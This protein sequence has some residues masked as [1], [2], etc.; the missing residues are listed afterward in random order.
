[1]HFLQKS[2]IPYRASHPLRRLP[3]AVGAILLI[4][5]LAACNGSSNTPTPTPTVGQLQYT[6]INLKLPTTAYSAQTVGPLPGTTI[7]KLGVSFKVNPKALPSSGNGTQVP[8]GQNN[9]L[10]KYANAYGITDATYQKIEKYLGVEGVTLNLGKLHSYMTVKAQASTVERLF[11]TQ[12]VEHR[13]DKRTYYIPTTAPR[14]PT[15]VMTYVLAITGLESYSTVA[16]GIVHQPA[17][18]QNTQGAL[19]TP[20]MPA[21]NKKQAT[22]NCN[23]GGGVYP[24]SIANSYGFNSFYKKGYSGQHM[25]VNLIELGGLMSSDMQN[26]FSCVNFP[27][28]QLKFVDVDDPPTQPSDEATLDVE[29]IA[30]LDNGATIMDYESDDTTAQTL[31]SLFVILNDELQAIVND[32]ASTNVNGSVVS[33]SY[34]WAED[35]LDPNVVAAIDQSLQTLVSVEHMTVFV[36]SGDCGAFIGGDPQHLDVSFPASDPWSTAVGGTELA[37]TGQGSRANE[38]VWG[39]HPAEATCKSNNWGSGGGVSTIFTIPS[40]QEGRGV[41]NQYSNGGRQLPDISA[42]ADDIPVYYDGHWIT[43]GGT[44]AATPIWGSA[45]VLLNQALIQNERAYIYGSDTF[46]DLENRAGAMLPYFD[47]VRGDNEYYKATL[48]WDNASGW[49]TPN[50]LNLYNAALRVY[51]KK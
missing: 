7:L 32:N 5:L 42:I 21:S 10:S 12:F 47:V 49:G 1:M 28:S 29:M 40:Y 30:G 33:I 16:P 36:A 34:G 27:T 17:F 20:L 11:Q 50:L 25:T 41:K 15:F 13:L 37:V 8:S 44:S 38:V 46:Y 14:L 9:D 39:E 2:T 6:T 4:I 26:Y 3:G 45:M 23:P 24:Q 22:A 31:D 18:S 48:S 19:S 35:Q 51:F 43:V